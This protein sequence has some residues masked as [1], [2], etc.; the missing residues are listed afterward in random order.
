MSFL[1][2]MRGDNAAMCPDLFF[3]LLFQR[4]QGSIWSFLLLQK[5]HEVVRTVRIP[6]TLPPFLSKHKLYE[7]RNEIMH[8][9]CFSASHSH[10]LVHIRKWYRNG[11]F[12]LFYFCFLRMKVPTGLCLTNWRTFVLNPQRLKAVRLVCEAKICR[13][14]FKTVRCFIFEQQ[15]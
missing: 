6:F 13:R 1:G 12:S 7:K 11:N 4:L 3:S 10:T 2:K 15:P 9:A 14:Y 5:Q 8:S